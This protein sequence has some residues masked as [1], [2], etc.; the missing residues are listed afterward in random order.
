[1]NSHINPIY[2]NILS[3]KLKHL[4][5]VTVENYEIHVFNLNKWHMRLCMHFLA[6]VYH[7]HITIN[8]TCNGIM[9][10][11]ILSFF[12][13]AFLNGRRKK[14]INNWIT[15]NRNITLGEAHVIFK[16]VIINSIARNL[17]AVSFSNKIIFIINNLEKKHCVKYQEIQNYYIHWNLKSLLTYKRGWIWTINNNNR[18]KYKFLA[19]Y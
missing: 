15:E 16:Y 19:L 3:K 1:M 5:F 12:A 17:F 14:I 2:V 10:F 6:V 7:V 18:H 11:A 8:C 9:L 13:K 4:T